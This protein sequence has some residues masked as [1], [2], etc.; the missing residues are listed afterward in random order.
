MA[1]TQATSGLI[2]NTGVTAGVYGGASAVPVI[3]INASGQV[4][5]A[6][7]TAFT[8]AT[9][10]NGTISLY[11]NTVSTTYTIDTNSNA[12]SVSPLT[13]ANGASVTIP[14]GQAWIIL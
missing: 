14:T 2:A 3:T 6:T 8:P 11:S 9:V 10:A 5:S 4:T 1:L 13:V 12:L 7:N